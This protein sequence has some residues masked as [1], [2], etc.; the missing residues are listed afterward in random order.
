MVSIQYRV[1]PFGFLYG[2][3]TDAPGNV[4]LHDQILGL[5]WIHYN[6]ARFGGDI[7]QVTIFGHEA[8]AMSV[9]SLILSPLAFRHF[10][11]AIMLSGSPI[12]YYGGTNQ[13]EALERTRQFAEKLECMNVN[14]SSVIECLRNKT[15]EQILSVT[16][17]Q[18]L[19][20]QMFLPIY[21]DELMPYKPSDALKEGKLNF[22]VD[23]LYGVNENEGLQYANL[24][25]ADQNN[26]TLESIKESIKWMMHY[27][28]DSSYSDIVFER[29]TSELLP[30][31]SKEMLL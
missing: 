4:G 19:K 9:G 10:R 24:F 11:R 2:N 28:G 13:S 30:N 22:G 16:K 20:N 29:Y 1:G 5:K 14:M 6:I 3:T 26:I 21:G 17:G 15:V 25:V 18:F 27:Y 31:A 8:G 12:S 23:L 7:A